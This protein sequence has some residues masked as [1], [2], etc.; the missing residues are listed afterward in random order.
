MVLTGRVPVF[1]RGKCI[2]LRVHRNLAIAV[3]L[4]LLSFAG[5][6]PA[7]RR[8]AGEIQ[9]NKSAGGKFDNYF[10][11]DAKPYPI[12]PE[13]AEKMKTAK[14]KEPSTVESTRLLN[15]DTTRVEGAPYLDFVW[16]W[17]GSAKGYA[18]AEH[19]H[20]FDEFIGFI[21]TQGQ[22]NPHDLG[23][24]MEVWLGGEKYS[25]TKSCL[26]YV[27]KG[28]KHCPIRFVR[29][30]TPILFFTGGMATKYSRTSTQFTDATASERNYAKY[31]SYDVNP[32]KLAAK[33]K[34]AGAETAPK[35]ISTVEGTRLLDL[36]SVEGA[37]Y[38]DFVWLWKGSE[39]T[40]N[41]PEHS[42]DWAEIFGFVGIKGQKDPNNLDGEM[43]LWLGGEKNLIT[44]SCLLYV[45]P[46]LKHCPFQ[47]NRID[48][49]I[50]LFTIGMTRKYTLTPSAKQ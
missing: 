21:G 49:P 35:R 25:I 20:D 22:Q 8:A 42:H 5:L 19:T 1:H 12:P 30:D 31:I 11:Y 16:L 23:G 7:P 37:P 32:N 18:E 14:K 29:I 45:P 50:L 9:G 15:M 17:K 4:L 28:L 6:S 24:E 33:K 44:K 36:D 13:M 38:I 40:P 43:E 10:V 26:I 39:N 41:H 27:P 47:F 2:M 34:P 46:N 3:S 48:S